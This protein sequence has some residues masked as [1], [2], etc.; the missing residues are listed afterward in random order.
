ML[1]SAHTVYTGMY[2]TVGWSDFA[3][4]WIFK[5]S[6]LL[7]IRYTSRSSLPKK[8]CMRGEVLTFKK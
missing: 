4:F 2:C 8:N 6:T 7:S 3:F 5:L 1:H